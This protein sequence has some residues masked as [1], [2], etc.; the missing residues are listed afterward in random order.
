VTISTIVREALEAH[1]GSPTSARRLDA[2]DASHPSCVELLRSH[3]GPLR[4]PAL[5]VAEVTHF[6]ERR[7]R[8]TAVTSPWSAR[9]TSSA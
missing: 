9:R 6:V 2:S 4:V 8:S 1:L 3:P 7:R 5:V